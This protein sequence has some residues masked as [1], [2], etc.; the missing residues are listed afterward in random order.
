MTSSYYIVDKNRTDNPSDD[1]TYVFNPSATLRTFELG[2]DSN[3]DTIAIN[4][5]SSDFKVKVKKDVMTLTGLKNGGS[6]GVII[7]IQLDNTTAAGGAGTLVFLDGAVDIDF[8]PSAAGSP[9]GAWT[10]GGT[11]VTKTLNLSKAGVTYAIDG[12]QAYGD[13]E[14]AAQRALS[15]QIFTLTST[16]DTMPGLI[17]SKGNAVTE[18]DDTILG[19]VSQEGSTFSLGDMINGGLGTDLLKLA[20][21]TTSINVFGGY[22]SNVEHFEMDAFG[23]DFETLDLNSKNF[24]TVTANFND[25]APLG[26][27]EFADVNKGSAVIVNDL[28]LDGYDLDV[29]YTGEG[30]IDNQAWFTNV[31]DGDVDLDFNHEDKAQ[32]EFL[33][34]LD[35]VDELE[36]EVGEDSGSV[37]TL[38]VRVEGAS[39]DV[40]INNDTD[41]EDGQAATVNLILNA[42]L[43]G[44]DWDLGD[45]GTDGVLTVNISGSGNLEVF[46]LTGDSEGDVI[47]N[48]AS[49]TGDLDI[50]LYD[51]DGVTSVKTGSGD[52]RVVLDND[53][54][55]E[56]GDITV[57]LGTGRNR[58]GISGVYNA[59]TLLAVDVSNV[60]LKLSTIQELEITG[61]LNIEKTTGLDNLELDLED[62]VAVQEV[63]FAGGVYSSDADGDYDI[64]TLKNGPDALTIS[65][66]ELYEVG[67]NAD[68]TKTLTIDSTSYLD[69]DLYGANLVT[70]TIKSE[71]SANVYGGGS[72]DKDD[73]ALFTNK[74]EKLTVESTEDSVC[75]DLSSTSAGGKQLTALKEISLI[76]S[77]VDAGDIGSAD[78]YLTG[79]AGTAASGQTT[80]TKESAAFTVVKNSGTNGVFTIHSSSL[81]GGKIDIAY[82]ANSAPS[83]AEVIR[84]NTLVNQY[85]NVTGSNA[86]IGLQWKELGN[87]GDIS[88]TTTGGHSYKDLV[89]SQGANPSDGTPATAGSGF[90]SLETVNVN[91]STDAWVWMQDAYGTF[92]LTAT[93]KDGDAGVELVDTNVNTVSIDASDSVTGYY[94]DTMTIENALKLQS[95]D[96]VAGDNVDLEMI[97]V[98][99]YATVSITAGTDVNLLLDDTLVSSVV[100]TTD[101]S[102]ELDDDD[103]Y[104]DIDTNNA[105]LKTITLVTDY[106]G[107]NVADGVNLLE[108][109][110]ITGV[111]EYADIDVTLAAAEL[112]QIVQIKIG[113]ADVD[114]Y[115][116][117]NNGT[118]ER[119]IFTTETGVVEIT[120]FDDAIGGGGDKL[121]FSQ[122]AGINTI[123]DLLFT[124]EGLNTRVTSLVAD[125][126]VDVLIIGDA[127][128][129][130]NSVIV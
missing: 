50:D 63:A 76:A 81:P 29:N 28:D 79:A 83:V 65:G 37:E 64:L 21:D 80:G 36:F 127:S 47:V 121:D 68:A 4:A 108:V 41:F 129:A 18:G 51:E 100:I 70:A 1:T 115:T 38:T 57:D 17:G 75:V 122:I 117:S 67:I 130:L 12:E 107:V 5:L 93:A 20:T 66:S 32:G 86:D 114:Y 14:I 82:T 99:A 25:M 33:I 109:I 87:K 123:N 113:G 53:Y 98:G 102:D 23:E 118:S 74:L 34:Q 8:T 46:D 54:F 43:S 55:V 111:V 72:T 126:D 15:G 69:I 49:A 92:D 44:E 3:G 40:E 39:T 116:T 95:V 9:K 73:A 13:V 101:T 110:D 48:G 7:K 35:S 10:F 120:G 60:N 106:A 31:R 77:G 119:F 61:E 6:P 30:A 128:L 16:Q 62:W 26:D 94:D 45:N 11:K 105:G 112:G 85:F 42:D 24:E 97:T 58:L 96:I 78:L 22:I 104:L 124:V 52:D 125:V 27:V 2:G 88:I 103:V 89:V 91:G 19:T 84:N 59:T 56:D 90:E 71:G